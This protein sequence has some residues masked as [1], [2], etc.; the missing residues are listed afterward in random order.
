MARAGIL[1][2]DVARAATELA[3]KGET[4]TVDNVRK[5]MGDTGSKSTIAPML[6]RWKEE[7]QD[8]VQAANSG[9]P[10]SILNAVRGVY[11]LLQ[12]DCEK[13]LAAMTSEHNELIQVEK[14][15]QATLTADIESLTASKITLE[16]QLA[17]TQEK[18]RS[19]EDLY[20]SLQLK[21]TGLQSEKDGLTLRLEDRNQEVRELKQKNAAMQNQFEHFQTATTNQR[22]DDR[23][24][25]ET[26][27]TQMESTLQ[28][29]RK[30][31]QILENNCVKHEAEIEQLLLINNEIANNAQKRKEELEALQITQYQT[32]FQLQEAK[33]ENLQLKNDLST[34]QLESQRLFT[35]AA[36]SAKLQEMLTE[37]LRQSEMKTK[38]VEEEKQSLMLELIKN[39]TNDVT[40]KENLN[41]SPAFESNSDQNMQGSQ[42][43]AP[44][45]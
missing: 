12:S 5:M 41:T 20:S 19:I 33:Q 25:Y 26:R 3:A 16:K 24:A 15:R 34:H 8:E 2:S 21:F 45:H 39:R 37:Q 43:V 4:A 28:L 29:A 27:I 42:I 10:E 23:R 18:L 22:S 9:L 7:H 36:V 35:S 30:N 1:Y 44:D 14:A 31:N 32:D 13:K 11:V 17:I 38:Q 6:K 40:S